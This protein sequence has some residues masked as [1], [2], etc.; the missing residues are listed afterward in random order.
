[1]LFTEKFIRKWRPIGSAS[2]SGH[3]YAAP[4]MARI[5]DD[6]VP[7]HEERQLIRASDGVLTVVPEAVGDTD[8][9]P[10][11]MVLLFRDAVHECVAP[12][13]TAGV[14]IPHLDPEPE[15]V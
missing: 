9:V 12:R 6:A 13:H 7:A 1:M 5:F 4:R 3:T 15:G 8:G 11:C 2:E 14:G 10:L